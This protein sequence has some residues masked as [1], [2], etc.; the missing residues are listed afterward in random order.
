MAF[1]K[2][3]LPPLKVLFV[4]SVNS[5]IL[6][7][8]SPPLKVLFVVGF[9]NGIVVED[10]VLI[11][12]RLKMVHTDIQILISFGSFENGFQFLCIVERAL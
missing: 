7:N 5:I 11:P 6:E 12:K 1:C 4:G 10:V 9:V 2:F 3:V 8:F